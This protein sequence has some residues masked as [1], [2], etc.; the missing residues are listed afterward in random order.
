MRSAAFN[1]LQLGVPNRWSA[2]IGGV[3]KMVQMFYNPS[4]NTCAQRHAC[5][6][7]YLSILSI[8]IHL[9]LS[10]YPSLFTLSYLIIS[11]LPIQIHPS[12]SASNAPAP[13]DP[14]GAR[15]WQLQEVLDARA[16]PGR[17]WKNRGVP[18]RCPWHKTR[19]QSDPIS[20]LKP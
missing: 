10:I 17:A 7:A 2:K 8:C 1:V 3:D 20:L 6:H 9:S 5:V 13:A 11:Y 4:A 18:R 15:T 14:A 12:V 16:W 19:I